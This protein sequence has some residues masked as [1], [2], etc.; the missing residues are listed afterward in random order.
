MKEIKPE[1]GPAKKVAVPLVPV[2]P[3]FDDDLTR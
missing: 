1:T 3:M 2:P